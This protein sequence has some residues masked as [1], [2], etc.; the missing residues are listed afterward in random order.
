MFFNL[1]MKKNIILFILI[2]SHKI[3]GQIKFGSVEY[4]QTTNVEIINERNL[5]KFELIK[6]FNEKYENATQRISYSLHF[7]ENESY[8]FA[9]KILLANDIN[10]NLAATAG[11]AKLKYYH[12]TLTNESRQYYDMPRTGIVIVNNQT[13]YEWTLTKETKI[14]DK[15]KCYKATSPLYYKDK[16]LDT[17][18]TAWY[19][20]EIPVGYGPIGYGG[21]PG[22]ILELQNDRATFF[23]TK[24]DLTLNSEPEINK[25]LSP[26]AIS[27]Q[28]FSDLIMGTLSREQ[29]EG[30]EETD[31]KK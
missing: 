25:L 1:F 15:Y 28:I 26:V 10:F 6:D 16:K 23:V 24:I 13:I 30:M 19:A 5:P 22:L 3:N 4:K 27:N 11:R 9:N 2:I 14:I 12:N 8:F 7:N 17:F 20:P 29:L 31:S 18:V 21:L